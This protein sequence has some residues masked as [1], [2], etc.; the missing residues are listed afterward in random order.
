MQTKELLINLIMITRL[1]AI[2]FIDEWLAENICEHHLLNSNE[3]N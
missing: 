1:T 2:V 3:V